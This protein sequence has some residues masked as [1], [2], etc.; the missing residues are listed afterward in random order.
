[1]SLPGRRP[2]SAVTGAVVVFALL[3]LGGALN[4]GAATTTKKVTFTVGMVGDIDSLNPF[5][6]IESSSYEMYQL[7]YETL[8]DYG[9]TDFSTKPALAESWESS[10][11]G[12]T[13]TY[14]LRAGLKSFCE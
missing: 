3:A 13:W 1:M 8:T 2:L 6:G 7:N 9:Q 10:A 11:D 4:S 14:H 12:L 5:T